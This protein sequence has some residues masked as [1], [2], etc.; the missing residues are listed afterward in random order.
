MDNNQA[1]RD[2]L[3]EK[4]YRDVVMKYVFIKAM[5]EK[6]DDEY[7]D[8][9][10]RINC[11]N[12]REKYNIIPEEERSRI[13]NDIRKQI[14]AGE[15]DLSKEAVNWHREGLMKYQNEKGLEIASIKGNEVKRS[16]IEG[17]ER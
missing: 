10:Y 7:L 15:I 6:Y 9:M 2:F 8:R 4:L 16:K 14:D 17:E 1:M 12:I 3:R 5:E 13:E 11:R